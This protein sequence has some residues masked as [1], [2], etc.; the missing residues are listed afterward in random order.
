MSEA[1]EMRLTGFKE[2]LAR[3]GETLEFRHGELEA[4]V[5]RGLNTAGVQKGEVNFLERDQTH[6]E[7]LKTAV[8]SVPRSGESLRDETGAYHR[9]KTVRRTDITYMLEC[10]QEPS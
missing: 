8:S 3:D 6:I 4:I 10:E 1:S 9:V 2:L 7:F 5:N